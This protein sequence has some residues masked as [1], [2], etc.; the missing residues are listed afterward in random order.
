MPYTL[1]NLLRRRCVRYALLFEPAVR[2]V[3]IFAL[4][5]GFSRCTAC[6]SLVGCLVV[7]ILYRCSLAALSLRAATALVLYTGMRRIRS[8]SQVFY[9]ARST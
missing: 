5:Y 9:C 6:R 7:S 3:G 8:P 2:A 1:S 4:P